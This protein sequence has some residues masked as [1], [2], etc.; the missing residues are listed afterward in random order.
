MTIN[1]I[2]KEIS[3][4]L[5][6]DFYAVILHDDLSLEL[7][8]KKYGGSWISQEPFDL[9][10]GDCWHFPLRK[11]AEHRIELQEDTLHIWFEHLDCFARFREN[12][13]RRPL[14]VP[15]F[16][17]HFSIQLQKEKL[18]F[19]TE[20]IEN[21]DEEDITLI[22]PN[23]L[24][25][26]SSSENV[27]CALPAGYG[28]L[29]NVPMKEHQ[30]FNML[31]FRNL[32]MVFYGILPEKRGGLAIY[33]KDFCDMYTRVWVNQIPDETAF[34]PV[35]RFNAQTS[36]YSRELHLYPFPPASDYN[37]LAKWY[38]ELTR[39]EGRFITLKEKIQKDP[40]VEKLVGSVIWKHDVYAMEKPPKKHGYSYFIM[41]QEQESV[42]GLAANWSAYEVFDKARESGF[43]RVCIF[44]AGWNRGGYDSMYPTRLPP[45]PERGTEEEFRKAAEY[46]RSLSDG[47][48]FSVHDNYIE[49]YKNSP[50]FKEEELV[51]D[52]RGG[53]VCGGIWRGGRAHRLCT[54]YSIEYAK[55]DLPQIAAMLGRG[56]IYIDVLGCTPPFASFTPGHVYGEREDL[57]NR[58]EILKIAKKEFGSV[59]TENNPQEYCIDL[60][61]LGAFS[62]FTTFMC[63]LPVIP[64]PL[65]QLV[66]HDSILNYTADASIFRC[67]HAQYMGLAALYGLLPTGFDPKSLELSQK[68]RS[69]YLAEMISHE[70]LTKP[71]FDKDY[72]LH[73]VAKSVFSDGTEVVAN[74]GS[75][76]Y[77]YQGICLKENEYII[78][79]ATENK[80]L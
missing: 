53:I 80:E 27:S 49:A 77:V 10:Y 57:K 7:K 12:Q 2:P 38:R 52:P 34:S 75:A 64:I 37:K 65:W 69:A 23:D 26:F 13:Y 35:Y 50:E 11:H 67:T 63:S 74:F 8:D 71:S 61:D 18:V 59:S 29:L 56:S 1:Q 20:K 54:D 15:D 25:R 31:N 42:E 22:F 76:A 45:N 46:G 58:R 14:N 48:I 44:N 79:S 70:F 66:Y 6:N 39:Q 17:F 60:V 62:S 47:Y 41:K 24:F 16:L 19:R 78:R 30:I 9:I 40:E 33:M 51:R 21:L 32:N 73:A 3:M 72:T 68:M 4:I 28:I 55:R 36:N 43:D 5:E